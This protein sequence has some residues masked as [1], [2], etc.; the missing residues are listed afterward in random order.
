VILKPLAV[1][2]EILAWVLQF[3]QGQQ[4]KDTH[5]KKADF[6]KRSV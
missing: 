5:A 2:D 4:R 1:T 6:K 3:V